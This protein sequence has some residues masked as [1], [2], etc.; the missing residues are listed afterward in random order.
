MTL[1]L[2]N[3]LD[4]WFNE[5]KKPLMITEYGADTVPGLHTVSYNNSFKMNV[6]QYLYVD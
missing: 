5:F 4:N 6:S 1:Q 2:K 3:D